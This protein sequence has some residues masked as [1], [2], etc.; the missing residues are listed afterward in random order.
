[1]EADLS[2]ARGKADRSLLETVSARLMLLTDIQSC[3]LACRN[4]ARAQNPHPNP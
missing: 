4:V 3:L 2:R 1:M